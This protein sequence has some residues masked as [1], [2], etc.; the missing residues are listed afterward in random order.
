MHHQ[1]Y[2]PRT[3]R[4]PRRRAGRALLLDG[5]RRHGPH[6]EPHAQRRRPL[7]PRAPAQAG[8]LRR[9]QGHGQRI[10]HHAQRAG[11]PPRPRRAARPQRV[12]AP[13]EHHGR[14]GR[15]LF[16][17]Q[18]QQ[19]RARAA[20]RLR[21]RGGR[22]D[23]HGARRAGAGAVHPHQRGQ[24]ARAGR[25]PARV[26]AAPAVADGDGGR[27]ARRTSFIICSA[28]QRWW[29]MVSRASLSF[30]SRCPAV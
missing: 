17:L 26:R 14:R 29:T 6:A 25:V 9:P 23:A 5:W 19:P 12:P 8:P 16:G 13:R 10:G 7:P 15:V 18:R 4:A 22:D 24:R 27:R 21:A 2:A 3:P 11:R 30:A 1:D 28:H 20:P